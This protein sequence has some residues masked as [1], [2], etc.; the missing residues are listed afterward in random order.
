MLASEPQFFQQGRPK[1]LIAGAGLGGLTLAVLL[2]KAGINFLLFDRSQEFKPL[3]ANVMLGPGT[4]RLFHQLE[5]YDEILKVGIRVADMNIFTDDLSLV[6]T[7]E[8]GWLED[9]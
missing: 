8:L 4:A 3:G 9:V 5:I 6:C 1:V 7:A 2:K